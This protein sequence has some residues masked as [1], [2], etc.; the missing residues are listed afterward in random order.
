MLSIKVALVCDH[1]TQYG[2]AE[3]VLHALH[4][5]FPK[6]PIYTLYADQKIVKKHFSNADVRTTALQKLPAK[7]RRKFRFVA[8]LAIS[9]VENI[10]L[11]E[12]N[13][14]ISSSAF[15][16]K[17]II[18]QP[19]AVHISYCHTPPRM[20][21]GVDVNPSALFAP[22]LHFLRM[23][24]FNS[25]FRVN[26]YVANSRTVQKRIKKYYK[27][28]SQVVYPPVVKKQEHTL[29]Q[30]AV[31]KQKLNHSIPPLF[32]LMVSSLHPH[33]KLDVVVDAF[34]KMKYTLVVVG[35]GPHKKSLQ[36]RAG[37]NVVLLGHQ[38]EEIVAEY[39][40]NCVAFIHSAEEDF[41]ISMAEAMLYGKPVLAFKRGGS[42]EIIQQNEHGMF[43]S[44]H[45]P[46]VFADTLRRL[47]DNIKK[48]QYNSADLQEHAQ[49]FHSDNFKKQIRDIV[50]Q[51]VVKMVNQTAEVR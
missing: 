5:M 26:R 38:P 30:I 31:H 17:G 33:K 13:V 1:L 2:G 40:K 12:F 9:A 48:G 22:A 27:Q 29:A 46:F 23:W 15:F 25:A 8:P 37:K 28:D 50:K 51:E 39:Y 18:T 19:N 32:F 14:I 10:D 3:R 24:D 43:F 20:L 11:S 35:D 49:Q 34:N 21:W 42:T 45:D 4:T 6:A 41:G 44:D 47:I 36:K 16:S 7:L